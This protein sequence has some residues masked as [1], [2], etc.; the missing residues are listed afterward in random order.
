M[1]PMKIYYE[2]IFVG[3]VVTNKSM[4]VDEAL[5]AISFDEQTFISEQGFDDLDFNDFRLDYSGN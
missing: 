5:Q 1:I 3:E 4:T 2:D